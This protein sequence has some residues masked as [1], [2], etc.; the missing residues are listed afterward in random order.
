MSRINKSALPFASPLE[1]SRLL[2]PLLAAMTAIDSADIAIGVSG[3]AD[4]AMLLVA[5]AQLAA[6]TQQTVQAV[7][8]HHGL[9]AD[10]DAWAAHTAQLAR[11]L[12]VAFHLLPVTVASGTGKGTE[13]AARQARYDAWQRWSQDNHCHHI[14]L[15][16]HRDDQAETV[17]LR[18]LRGAGVQG[19]SGMAAQTQRGALQLYRPWL[20]VERSRI[21][22]AAAGYEAQTGW[23]PVLDPTNLDAKYT[24]AAVRTLLTPVLNTRWPQWQGNL[25]RHAR[26]MSEN[27]LLLQDLGELDLAHCQLTPNGLSFSLAR[28]RELP[29]HRQ[30]NVLRQWLRRQHIA[31]PTEARLNQWL[32]QLREVHAL[33]H[34]RNILLQHQGCHIVCRQGQVQLQMNDGV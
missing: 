29:R 25:L 9:L 33:G 32:R 13:A 23:I 14:L 24:R 8:V 11:D 16:H 2:Q 10:A 7:H 17:L 19:M 31:M 1:D 21:L 28:W 3:G 34:D 26:V 22:A 30:A 15:A 27:T 4:S 12:G 18:L 6:Q 20:D 5:A